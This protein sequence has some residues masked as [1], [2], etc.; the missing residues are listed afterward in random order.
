MGV[1]IACVL[2]LGGVV[3]QLP[4]ADHWAATFL[5]LTSA[6]ARDSHSLCPRR[7]RHLW[8]V[9]EVA[10]DPG[11]HMHVCMHTIQGPELWIERAQ[12][13]AVQMRRAEANSI[14]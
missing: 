14:M 7:S 6:T 3:S 12:R 5:T 8:L 10:V 2:H 4:G 1:R 11:V 13:T 9:A